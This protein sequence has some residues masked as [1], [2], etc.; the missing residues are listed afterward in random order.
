MVTHFPHASHLPHL[1]SILSS[2]AAACFWL[3]VA[4]QISI[5]GCIRPQCMFAYIIVQ[6]SVHHP[7]RWYGVT[8][9]RSVQVARPPK[10]HPHRDHG[11]SVGC[12]IVCSNGGHLRPRP[13]PSLYFLRDCVS[14]PQM[15]EP[16]MVRAQPT[17]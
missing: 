13:R 11:L 1:P 10:Y 12:C 9:T 7:K 4:I 17:P 6:R 15:K 16:T 8:P 5:G 2:V 14:A 3:V